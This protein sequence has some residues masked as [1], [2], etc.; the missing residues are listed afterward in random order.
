MTCFFCK[1]S[2]KESATT[3]VVDLKKCIVIVKNAPC[4]E[5]EKCGEAVYTHEVALQLEK[6]V[7]NAATIITEIAVV[8]YSEKAA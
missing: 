5:C 6:I 3:H 4:R 1:G 8:N 7:K 2:M